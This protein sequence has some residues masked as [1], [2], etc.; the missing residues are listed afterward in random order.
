MLSFFALVRKSKGN[1]DALPS[2]VNEITGK[3]PDFHIVHQTPNVCVLMTDPEEK[4]TFVY[5]LS[6]GTGLILGTL[7]HKDEAL[8][9][10]APLAIDEKTTNA[11]L[12]TRCQYIIEKYWGMYAAIV[13]K[14][15]GT[16]QFI[17][18]DPTG[19]LPVYIYET[20]DLYLF[21]SDGEHFRS[22][23]L[24]QLSLDPHSAI[25][26]LQLPLLHLPGTC[27]REIDKVMP[28]ELFAISRDKTERFMLWKPRDFFVKDGNYT[29]EKAAAELR[30]T[31]LKCTHAWASH[32]DKICVRASGGLD[33]SIIL[34]CTALAPHRPEVIAV[35]H[36]TEGNVDSDEREFARAAAQ[37]ANAH[38]IEVRDSADDIDMKDLH[39]FAFLPKFYKDRFM[40]GRARYQKRLADEHGI[41]AFFGG[42]P[43]D[44]IFY[45]R[46]SYTA[47]DY[48]YH[49]GLNGG[50]FKACY[51]EALISKRPI[52]AILLEA[53]A[54]TIRTP[55]WCLS[56]KFEGYTGLFAEDLLHETSIDAAL[57]PWEQCQEGSTISKK[58]QL[59]FTFIW[60]PYAKPSR[61]CD[62]VRMV[63]PLMSQPV[64][65]AV[66]RIPSYLFAYN[67][68]DRG[69]ARLAFL[70]I[71]HPTNMLRKSKGGPEDFYKSV[72]SQNVDFIRE[73]MLD[74]LLVKHG[75][76]D[77]KKVE[78]AFSLALD[79]S[80]GVWGEVFNLVG[81]EFWARRWLKT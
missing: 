29:T 54:S 21:F 72:W 32:F 42:E 48:L 46:P 36:Y 80:L 76:L 40:I 37:H 56:K 55:S 70:D 58:E 50:F 63:E 26:G 69:L 20:P 60:L 17:L 34:S 27:L 16:E 9:N 81:N 79:Q 6:G 43:G 18:R 78:N 51:E 25:L 52:G 74:G 33:S 35:T 61:R 7:F 39:D 68:E 14:E 65:E 30:T 45:T 47:I 3:L 67:G 77:R 15:D 23:H 11:I 1:P 5:R 4:G 41:D 10:H 59:A 24:G 49:K 22:L 62:Y 31:V 38:L 13:G 2:R 53:A 75:L 73:A 12:D 44:T 64:L 66:C 8:T 57:A 28:G 19:V 71:G